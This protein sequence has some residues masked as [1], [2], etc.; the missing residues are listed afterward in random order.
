VTAWDAREVEERLSERAA[1]VAARRAAIR[2]EGAGALDGELSHLGN[3]PADQGSETH[4][5][6]LYLTTEV[7]L[8]EE[9][10]R[11]DDARAAIA[12]GTYGRCRECHEAIA[13]RRLEAVPEA[14]L[15][16]TCQRASEAHHRQVHGNTQI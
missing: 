4:E 5:Q 13:P 3:H 10:R 14:V 8:D 9:Q 11:I 12:A 2:R 16:L 15:C 6:E 1:E 7:L